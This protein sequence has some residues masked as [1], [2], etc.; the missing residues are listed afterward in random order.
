M[1]ILKRPDCEIYYELKGQ[2]QPVMLIQGVGVIG[3][4]WRPQV[5]FLSQGFQTLIYDNRGIGKSSKCTG[6]ISIEA[7]AEDAKA[8]LDEV[9]WTAGHVVGHSMGGVVAQQLA[10]NHPKLIRS[11]TLMCT[12]FRGKDAMRMD[13][14]V[15]WAGMRTRLGTKRMRRQGFLD[16]I[17]TRDYLLTQNCEELAARLM[18]L[19]GRDLAESPPILMKQ[20]MAM[21]KSDLSKNLNKLSEIPT[22]VISGEKDP[23]A[24]AKYGE[25]LA[26]NIKGAK[27]QIVKNESHAVPINNSKHINQLLTEFLCSH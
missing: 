16:M 7:M 18:P 1:P 21:S 10:L 25:L 11:L 20:M 26:Q 12:F 24:L 22:Y 9:G 5:D 2:G 6:P 4:C 3:E 13:R 27:L 19:M 15:M 23:I 8:L 14:K 17:F